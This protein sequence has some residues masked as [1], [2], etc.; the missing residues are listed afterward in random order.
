MMARRARIAYKG[1]ARLLSNVE[2]RV[3]LYSDRTQVLVTTTPGCQPR[4]K[5]CGVRMYGDACMLGQ[6]V[7]IVNIGLD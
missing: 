2:Q 1:N 5:Y 7:D 4:K 3:W 6:M